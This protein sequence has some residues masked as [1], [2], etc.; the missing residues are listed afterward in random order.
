LAEADEAAISDRVGSRSVARLAPA[1]LDAFI[2]L[3]ITADL[4]SKARVHRVTDSQAREVY[5][6]TGSATKDMSGLV[7]PYFSIATGKRVTA[8]VRRDNPEIEAGKEKDK[9]LS[10]YGDRKHL[11]FPPDAAIKL[12]NSETVIVLVEAEKSSLALTAWAERTGTANLL[13]VAMG[14]CWGWR[15]RIGKAVNAHGDRV[16]EMGPIPDL[17][18]CNGRKV[19]VL[20]DANVGTN[21]N[22]RQ[23]QRALVAEL[24]KRQCEALVCDLP[25]VVSVNGPDDY[26]ARCGDEAMAQV[27]VNAHRAADLSPQSSEDSLA[28]TFT[29]QY[30]SD[31]RY[32]AEWG[33]WSE[34]DGTRWKQD[35]TRKVFDFARRICREA[36]SKFEK[37]SAIRIAS[38]ATVAAVERLARSDRRHTATVEQWDADPWL[39]NTP[40]GAVDLT[41]GEMRAAKREDYCTKITTVVPG[42]NCPMWFEFLARITDRNEA[43]QYFIQRMCGY[44]LTG[45]TREHTLFFL[46]GT[47]ANGKSVFINTISGVMG[48]YARTAPIETFI[49]SVSERHPTDLAGLQGARLITAVET[50]DGRRWAESKLKTLTGGDRIAARFMRQDFFEFTPQFKLLIAGN[51]KPGLRSVDEAMRRRLKLLPFTVTIPAPERDFELADKLRAEWGGILEWMIEGCLSWQR[52]GL[53]APEVVTRATEE[54]LASEDILARWIEDCCVTKLTFWTA[55]AAL[56]KSWR[57]WCD[58]NEEYSCSQRRFS[59][60]LESRGFAARRT[61]KARGFDGIGLVTDVTG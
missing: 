3:G 24:R 44:A 25:E 53:N 41:T 8:R 14:G 39:L 34:W 28:L 46:Y 32:T 49:A 5:G 61:N 47:G 52:K 16:D 36:S 51:H 23:A 42:G 10:A 26:I 45:I 4:L 37:Q 21:A 29:A 57:D 15:G 54:Y 22:V 19:Y 27:Y 2:R 55:T 33:H 1:D 13:P 11:Y 35:A 31:L 7:F 18:C 59:E 48:G 50:E 9:Y 30:G 60:Q 20:L 17:D 43:L 58:R 6:I 12:R 40:G 38:A 56:F